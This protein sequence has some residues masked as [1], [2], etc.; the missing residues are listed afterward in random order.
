M[1]TY[2]TIAVGTDGSPTS[3]RAVRAAASMARAYEAKL[4]IISAFYNQPGASTLR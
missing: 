4:I 2:D 1:L 3:L